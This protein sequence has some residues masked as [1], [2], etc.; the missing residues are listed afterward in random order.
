MTT[1]H[2]KQIA[3][4]EDQYR[5]DRS[6]VSRAKP[7]LTLPVYLGEPKNNC[8][9]RVQL[10]KPGTNVTS[11]LIR[12]AYISSPGPMNFKKGEM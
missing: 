8:V 10:P 3:K 4:R 6:I 11:Y 1:K 5:D 2:V 12:T 9:V 7:C